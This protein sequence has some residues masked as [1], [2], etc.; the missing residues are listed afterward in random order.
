MQLPMLAPTIWIGS[1][2]SPVPARREARRDA[3][4]PATIVRV[5]DIDARPSATLS[6]RASA[7]LILPEGAADRRNVA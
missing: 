4:T 2:E 5:I 7:R 6:A 1:P 3:A